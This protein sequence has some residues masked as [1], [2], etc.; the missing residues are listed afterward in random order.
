MAGV[1]LN[2]AITLRVYALFRHQPFYRSNQIDSAWTEISEYVQG[3]NTFTGRRNFDTLEFDLGEARIILN[4]QDRRFDPTNLS[5]PYVA[6]SKTQV[7]P[8]V[9]IK[10]LYEYTTYN[11][12]TTSNETNT[13]ALFSG[14]ATDWK[15]I[16]DEYGQIQ[17]CELK[18]LD[19]LYMLKQYRYT[20]SRGSDY[21][22]TVAYDIIQDMIGQVATMSGESSA[23][24]GYQNNVLTTGFSSSSYFPARDYD[25]PA[26]DAISDI[27]WSANAFVMAAP[28]GV[29]YSTRLATDKDAINYDGTYTS[30]SGFRK[31]LF[32]G[33]DSIVTFDPAGDIPATSSSTTVPY[34]RITFGASKDKVKTSVN[35][36]PIGAL[37]TFQTSTSTQGVGDYGQMS[38]TRSGNLYNSSGI[39]LSNTRRDVQTFYDADVL[40]DTITI[41]VHLT[42]IINKDSAWDKFLRGLCGD[43]VSTTTTDPYTDTKFTIFTK[44]TVNATMPDGS[45]LSKRFVKGGIQTEINVNNKIF[46][47]KLHLEPVSVPRAWLLGKTDYSELRVATIL[48]IP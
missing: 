45:T 11:T 4:N 35:Y 18:A 31:N 40:V 30:T 8:N 21:P 2:E 44:C 13:Y 5:G 38:I 34:S 15:Q 29:L 17:Q 39:A 10:V 14:F 6:S 33:Y 24:F 41:P 27:Y 37:T 48:S 47:V 22:W 3:V 7:K 23:S 43:Q 36:S 1:K 42:S 32:N 28:S 19:L 9:Q 12:S 25:Q 16:F 26:L 20:E 46:N